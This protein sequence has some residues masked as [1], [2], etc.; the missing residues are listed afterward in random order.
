[1]YVRPKHFIRYMCTWVCTA[2][3]SIVEI[4]R[5]WSRALYCTTSFTTRFALRLRKLFMGREIYSSSMGVD[6]AEWPFPADWN[7]G[8]NCFIFAI[9]TMRLNSPKSKK[10]NED[11]MLDQPELNHKDEYTEQTTY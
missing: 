8:V 3:T 6:S 7:R 10:K 9:F 11:E 5:D 2:S 1:M 4:E